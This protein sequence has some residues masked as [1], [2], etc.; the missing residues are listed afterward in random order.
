MEMTAINKINWIL[1]E[2]LISV[3]LML[4]ALQTANAGGVEEGSKTIIVSTDGIAKVIDSNGEISL[5][6]VDRNIEKGEIK[7]GVILTDTPTFQA[8]NVNRYQ[9][10]YRGGKVC[11]NDKLNTDLMTIY[12]HPFDEE[13]QHNYCIVE[14]K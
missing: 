14:I 11:V 1:L 4:V 5:S 7:F 9:T 2:L 8:N 10:H 12:L 3:L 6:S 13:N